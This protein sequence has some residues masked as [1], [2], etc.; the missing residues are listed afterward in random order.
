MSDGSSF[1]GPLSYQP[2]WLWLGLLL[3]V[4]VAA[5][6]GWLLWPAKPRRLGGHETVVSPARDV[7]ALRAACLAGIAAVEKDADDGTLPMRE[8]HQRLSF[9]VREFA[10]AATGLPATSMTLQELRGNG[11]GHFAAGI[12]AIYPGE[13][14]PAAGSPVSAAADTAR[15]A[16]LGWN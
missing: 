4:T 11:L 7:E 10:A 8:A 3:A 9:L 13:F 1:Y 12:A 2:L 14:A 15:R 16:V 6:Y 5:W